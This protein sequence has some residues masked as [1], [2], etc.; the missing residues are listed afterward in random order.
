MTNLLLIAAIIQIESGGNNLAV[1][2]HGRAIGALQIQSH[3][4][5]DVN[6]F[7]G[8]SYSHAQ[9]TNRAIAQFVFNA[10]LWIYATPARLGRA[11]TD[12][13]RMRIWNG[14]PNGWRRRTTL[15]YVKKVIHKLK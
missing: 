10:Y 15:C 12:I 13:D 1:G 2:D 11:V 14:G 4:V 7:F 9:M 6:K 5:R 8:T 3:V